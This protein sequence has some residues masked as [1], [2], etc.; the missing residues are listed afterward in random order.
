MR[1]YSALLSPFLVQLVCLWFVCGAST[2]HAEKPAPGEG[3]GPAFAKRQELYKHSGIDPSMIRIDADANR[4]IERVKV[5][6]NIPLVEF[7]LQLWNTLQRQDLGSVDVLEKRRGAA[8]Q[9]EIRFRD[10][11][12]DWLIVL[13]YGDALRRFAFVLILEGIESAEP[14]LVEEFT[15]IS[16]FFGYVVA[17]AGLAMACSALQ[18][19]GEII[20]QLPF[21]PLRAGPDGPEPILLQTAGNQVR[22]SLRFLRGASCIISGV[23]PPENSVVLRDERIMRIVLEEI[24]KRKTYFLETGSPRSAAAKEAA[25]AFSVPYLA[26]RDIIDLTDPDRAEAQIRRLVMAAEKTGK[27]V[28]KGRISE[29]MLVLIRKLS[30]ELEGGSMEFR[31]P[32]ALLSPR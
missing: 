8:K 27:A 9:I 16:P 1:R 15:R 22:K 14:R 13:E 7:A 21:E 2:A 29:K 23:V 17:P 26:C 24:Q 4:T 6:R 32:A 19:R 11:S 3:Y 30:P 31:S 25:A 12:R 5:P 20:A 28:A 10:G 18:G